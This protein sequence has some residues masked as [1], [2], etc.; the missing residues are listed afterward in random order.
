MPDLELFGVYFGP[1]E[2]LIRISLKTGRVNSGRYRE[3]II[4]L[5]FFTYSVWVDHTNIWF[6][7]DGEHC[8]HR[9]YFGSKLPEVYKS[10]LELKIFCRMIS[11]KILKSCTQLILSNID[12]KNFTWLKI[13]KYKFNQIILFIVKTSLAHIIIIK[14]LIQKHYNLSTAT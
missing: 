5:F 12:E 10:Q 2:T 11:K 9:P 3:M 6:Q 14:I 1:V 4:D 13:W 7:Q 8:D